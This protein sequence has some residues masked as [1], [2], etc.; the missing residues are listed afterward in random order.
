MM[1]QNHLKLNTNYFFREKDEFGPV[2]THFSELSLYMVSGYGCEDHFLEDDTFLHS[3]QVLACILKSPV[4]QDIVCDIGMPIQHK[5]VRYNCKVIF[6]NRKIL[7]IRPKM[8]MANDGN[9]R[10]M[11]WFSPWHQVR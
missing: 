2:K 4:A 5:N 9:Y 7:L 3:F 8:A 11:R 10:E 6:Y 1:S